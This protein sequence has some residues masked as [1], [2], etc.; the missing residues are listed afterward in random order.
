[1]YQRPR[2]ICV[3]FCASIDVFC[4]CILCGRE[5]V[6][7][8]HDLEAR[9]RQRAVEVEEKLMAWRRDIH[10]HPEL[11]DQEVRTSGLVAEHLRGLK[12][13][14][15]RTGVARTGVVGILKGAKP[16]PTVALRADMDALPVQEPEGLPFASKAVAMMHG[17]KVPVMHACGHD[18]HT[19]ILMAVAEVLAAS[20]EDLPGTVM[21]IFQPAEE[22]S[23][24]VTPASGKSWGAKLMLEEGIFEKTRPAAIFALHVMPGP[25]GQISYRNGPTLASSDSLTIAIR[26]KQGHGGMPWNTIDPITTSAQVISGL[27]TVV[28]R[29]ANL[30]ASPTVVTIGTINGGTNANIVPDVV[31]MTGT[32]RTYDEG[33]RRQVHRDVSLAA[34]K[35]SEG[36]GAKAT[37]TISK[38][39]DAT[40]NDEGLANRM[41][42][43]LKRAADGDVVRAPL[44]GA[45]EDFSF[46]A[47][48]T[49]GMYVFLGGDAARPESG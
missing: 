40:I 42:P 34:E 25:S 41:L 49:P 26:G 28:S 46:F 7:R 29:K 2:T 48:A 47:K 20:R 21:F 31:E 27:Q 37:V 5:A 16:G 39:Y 12:L 15:L 4:G 6:A 33:V 11:G 19:A 13:N 36:S 10:E 30:T 1:M 9:I 45:A 32:I 3:F 18:A 22:G 43:A 35:I 8:E 17:K 38:M 14:E 44:A 24:M 23:S